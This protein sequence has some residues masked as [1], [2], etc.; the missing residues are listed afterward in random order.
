MLKCVDKIH[1]YNGKN[2]RSQTSWGVLDESS[3]SIPPHMSPFSL[4][5]EDTG[6]SLQPDIYTSAYIRPRYANPIYFSSNQVHWIPSLNKLMEIRPHFHSTNDA[7]QTKVHEN[8]RNDKKGTYWM[9]KK[10]TFGENRG[11]TT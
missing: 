7:F 4:F 2:P 6:Y 10:L 11:L 5:I 8:I 1:L 9:F 3:I